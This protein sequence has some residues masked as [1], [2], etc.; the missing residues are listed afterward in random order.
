[1]KNLAIR[2]LIASVVVVISIGGRLAYAGV[3]Y[4]ATGSGGVNGELVILNQATGAVQTDI[5]AL[6]DASQNAY[7]ITGLAFDPNTGI[8]YGSTGTASPTAAAHLVVIDPATALVTD[9]GPYSVPGDSTMSDIT[10]DP[11]SGILYGWEASGDHSLATIDLST[12]AATLVGTFSRPEFGG[13][14]LASDASGTLYATPDGSTAAKPTLRT[15]D[16]VT[17]ATTNVAFLSGSPLS[18]QS[19]N[20][21]AFSD[22]GTLYGVNNN[23]S[24]ATHLVTIDTAT[25]VMTDVGASLDNL[26]AIAFQSGTPPVPE[27]STLVLSSILVGVFG[28]AWVRKRLKRTAPVA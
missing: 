13:G 28:S 12:G 10:F 20:A 9:I 15:V 7:G 1:M 23:R 17:G 27:P 21:M 24:G 16:N 3:L 25:G 22:L 8:L 6:V 18:K 5:G 2:G 11:T 14:A 19:I 4:G 26:D